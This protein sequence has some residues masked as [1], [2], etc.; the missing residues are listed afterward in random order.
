MYWQTRIWLACLFVNLGMTLRILYPQIGMLWI[1]IPVLAMLS[2]WL[3]VFLCSVLSCCFVVFLSYWLKSSKPM[4]IFKNI[5]TA[6]FGF[7]GY[8]LKFW[9]RKFPFEES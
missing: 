1:L 9:D 8:E 5:S 4:V 2:C 7:F 6:F 3:V